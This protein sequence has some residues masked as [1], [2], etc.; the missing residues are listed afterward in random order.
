MMVRIITRN[1]MKRLMAMALM[2]LQR[3]WLRTWSKHW[4][5]KKAVGYLCPYFEFFCIHFHLIKCGSSLKGDKSW[6][7]GSFC[8]KYA[9]ANSLPWHFFQVYGVLDVQRVAGNFHISVHGLN[10]F[11]AQMV[12]PLLHFP[13]LW[14][15]SLVFCQLY[16]LDFIF[17]LDLSLIDFVK[18]NA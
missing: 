13:F 1:Q 5:M 15:W 2:R 18:P 17:I 3:K 14:H 8:S 4:Q 9:I 11:V 10:I 16:M 6:V 12:M 7:A